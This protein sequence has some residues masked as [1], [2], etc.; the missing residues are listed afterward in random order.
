MNKTLNLQQRIFVTVVGVSAIIYILSV[1]YISFNSRNA[2]MNDAMSVTVA[3]AQK[4]ASDMRIML[5]K[6][7]I[8]AQ[9]LAQTVRSYT[10]MPEEQWKKIFPKIY[11]DVME[12]NPHL[13]SVWDSWELKQI[14]KNYTKDYGRYKAELWREGNQIKS[15]FYLSSLTGDG[16]EYARIKANP[17]DWL[18][19]PY[20][21]N[22]TGNEK[23]NI[24]MTSLITPI[25][26]E[27][28]YIGVVGLDI[29][30][31]SLYHIVKQV[32]PFEQSF[33]FLLSSD[34]KYVSHPDRD[35][36]GSNALEDY[37]DIFN[38]F[39]VVERIAN[40][41]EV[42]FMAHDINGINSFFVFAPIVVGQTRSPWSMAV[43]VPKS[44]LL[45]QANRNLTISIIVGIIGLLILSTVIILFS[46]ALFNP[47]STITGTLKRMAQGN[48]SEDMIL[49]V[50]ANDEIGQMTVALNTTINGLSHKVDFATSI[51]KGNLDAH[52]IKLSEEDAL[53]KALMDMRSS[54]KQAHDENEMRKAE[55]N[56]R[57]WSNEALAKFA[58]ILRQ[59]NDNLDKLSKAI[60]RE[61]VNTL[62]ANQGG[63]FL[64]NDDEAN[65]QFFELKAAFAYNRI[66]HKQKNI[67]VGEGLIGACALE[68][69]SI[70]LTEIPEGYIE[71]TSGLGESTPNALLIVP[72][73]LDDTV[74]GVIEIASFS[75]FE[76]YQVDLVER[77]A[78][79][80]ASTITTV[81]VSIR[82]AE[83][84]TKTQQQAEEMLAQEEEM[85]QNM[86]ELQATQ[87]ESTRRTSEMQCFIE[88]LNNSSFVI[89]Y[90]S[91]GYITSINDSYLDLL[92]LSRDEV[93]GTHHSDKLEFS[94]E[95]KREYD[96]FWSNLRNGI[97]QKQ[98][99]R[100]TVNNHTFVFQETY[101][102]IKN[103]L[104]EVYKI[105]KI[106][107]NIT[108]L[109]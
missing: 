85:R 84:L 91:L 48:V 32:K 103:E 47:I 9:T 17:K 18:E 43:V 59:D 58:E 66:K 106:S 37:E 40:G 28:N 4:Y 100:F 90:D 41:Q 1:G 39:G 96:T 101:T 68:K 88:A 56:L 14:D 11:T 60:I 71:I 36:L 24:L 46:R 33:A 12:K 26:N 13:L 16:A 10:Q 69:K 3:T 54:L 5:E 79:S 55:D 31:E 34:L 42:S 15:R 19:N 98:V 80:I 89:E 99:N 50:K 76:T 95:Q 35:R 73:M 102:P 51:G 64:L 82:T 109:L 87:E 78:Q 6:D 22:F 93:M 8:T 97:P 67:L 53:G 27:G 65:N 105:L 104:G 70:I 2:A 61:V 20:L 75:E 38:N 62:G 86:E 63:L 45:A 21:A 49:P 25:T 30:L 7:L 81:R 23:D 52:F 29:A 94:P 92:G 77:L 83:L 74:L 107:N 57:R 44:V 72:L 108:N